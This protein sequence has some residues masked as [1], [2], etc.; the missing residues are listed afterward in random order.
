MQDRLTAQLVSTITRTGSGHHAGAVPVFLVEG[1]PRA[2][3]HADIAVNA[4]ST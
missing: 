2:L 4:A 1:V 3:E